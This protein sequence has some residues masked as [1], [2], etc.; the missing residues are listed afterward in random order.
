[1]KIEVHHIPASGL[2]LEFERP[3]RDFPGLKALVDNGEC[4]FVDALVVRLNV[5]PMRDFIRV[6]GHLEARVRQ[7]CGRCLAGFEAP[8]RS[9][10]TLDYSRKIPQDVHKNGAE[11]IEVT[12]DQIGMIYFEGEEIDFTD[13]IQEQVILAI[14]FNPVCKPEC[15]GLCPRCGSDLNV[16]GCRCSN[17]T[18]DGPFAVL[19]DI[20]LQLKKGKGTEP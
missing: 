14:P 15:K 12:A 5:L 19:K 6:K 3:V 18:P 8:L 7:E 2:S 10:F 13:A 9:R 16:E 17:P 4:Q 11:G 1:M 20:K